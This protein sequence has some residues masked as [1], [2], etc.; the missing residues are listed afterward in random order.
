[1]ESR[2]EGKADWQTDRQHLLQIHTH[3]IFSDCFPQ[4]NGLSCFTL[5]HLSSPPEYKNHSVASGTWQRAQSVHLTDRTPWISESRHADIQQTDCQVFLWFVLRLL[6]E[7]RCIMSSVSPE[8][9]CQVWEVTMMLS[10]WCYQG[11]YFGLG[12]KWKR[13]KYKWRFKV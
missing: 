5:I 1:M 8:D 4:I 12:L 9:L 11:G 2:G 6:R 7:I 3:N 13:L 10:S